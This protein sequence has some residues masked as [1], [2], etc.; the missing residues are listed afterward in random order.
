MTGL[1]PSRSVAQAVIGRTLAF[2]LL[3]WALREGA[4]TSL[5]HD[6]PIAAVA[7]VLSVRLAPPGPARIRIGAALRFVPYLGWMML[8]GGFDAARRALQ[9]SLPIN[10]GIVRPARLSRAVESGVLLGYATS[11]QPGT[12]AAGFDPDNIHMHVIDCQAPVPEKVRA[13]EQRLIGLF[14][15]GTDRD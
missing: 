2:A 12:V 8:A 15:K 13:L 10:P 5:S 6:L 3:W 9:P 14:R 7:G 4:L 11:L 1:L